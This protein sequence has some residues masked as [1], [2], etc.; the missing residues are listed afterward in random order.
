[1]RRSIS[2]T[3]LLFTSVSAI[4]G[5]GWLFAAYYTSTITGPSAVISWVLGAILV[6][7]VAY[8]FA[9]ISAMI[10]ITA[11]ST[12]IPHFTHG[13]IVS[14]LFA[15]ILWLSY[16]S[17]TPT[18]VQ[19][20][21]QYLSYFFPSLIVPSTGGLT[22]VGFA[23]AVVLMFVLSVLNI[24]S[25]RWVIRA[26]SLLT[27]LKLAIPVI[28]SV[29]V[30]SLFF[31]SPTPA[32][33]LH[34]DL[35]PTGAQGVFGAM[36]AGGVVFAFNGFKQACEM[37]GEAKNPKKSLPIAVIGSIA[38]TLIVYLLLQFTFLSSISHEEIAHGWTNLHL[39]QGNSPFANI[40]AEKHFPTL[41]TLLFIGAVISPL[42]AALVYVSSASRSLYGMSQ[43]D[44]LP[45]IF[46]KVSANG[47]PFIAIIFNFGIGLCLFLP[48]PGWNRMV[49]FLTSLMAITYAVAP[50]CVLTLR[51]QLPN[52]PRP[53][54]L[55]FIN[56]WSYVAFLICTLLMY[57]S[58]WDIISKL[59]IA[60]ITG[61]MILL[62][63]HFGTARGRL[64]KLDWKPALW[65]WP[66]F[67]GTTLLSYLGS[68]GHGRNII[69]FG[70]DFL[71][72]AIFCAFILWIAQ[73]FRLPADIT[74]KAVDALK[75]ERT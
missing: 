15:W 28:I 40:L 71:C 27:I 67:L 54:K 72:I 49:T 32:A 37:A 30:L 57:W 18:E 22:G 48:L 12:R 26:N 75:L 56:V 36:A 9:E 65:I 1:M 29:V 55:P 3:A 64:L 43:N 19:A 66:Y 74:K 8:T 61:L 68:F 13:S 60:L 38:I 53:F 5:S 4:L 14:F 50:I 24:Y 58:G 17:L 47:N 21:L 39:V 41:L 59:G 34:H 2:T 62:V 7:I 70:W 23:C 16:T 6:I 35:F 45:S 42:A 20:V 63:Y 52:Y 69:P 73:R 10:P 51:K 11:S 33:F 46:Q 31:Y 44:Y 25:L